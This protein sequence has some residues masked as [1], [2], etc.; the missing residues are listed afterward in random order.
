MANSTRETTETTEADRRALFSVADCLIARAG[1][2]TLVMALRG[3]RAQKVMRHGL[4]RTAGYGYFSGRPESEVL[5]RVDALIAEGSLRLEYHDG[6][7]LI[8]YTARGLQEAMRYAA[9]D[10]LA[11]LASQVD[12]VRQGRT[13]EFPPVLRDIQ[14]RNQNTVLLLAELVSQTADARWL[15]LLRA[16]AAGETRRVRGKLHPII[17]KLEQPA[18]S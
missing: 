11:A 10:W 8:V 2:T 7:P 9:E 1:R 3:S 13:P 12:P 5:A 4:D 15:P 17:A 16:W 18:T 6:Y 14:G